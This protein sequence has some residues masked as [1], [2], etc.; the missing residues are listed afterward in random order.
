MRM[1]EIGLPLKETASYASLG[2]ASSLFSQIVSIYLIY[3]YTDVM[4]IPPGYVAVLFLVSHIW[5][6]VNDQIFGYL[7]CRTK[8]RFG[9]YRPYLLW[10]AFPMAALTILLFL[11]PAFTLGW[12][13][14][15]AYVLYFLWD[16][17]MTLLNLSTN[18]LLPMI[19]AGLSERTRLNSSRIIFSVAATLLISFTPNFVNLLGGGNLGLTVMGNP[20][21]GY[22]LTAAVYAAMAV[23]LLLFAFR[24][25]REKYA[26]SA[27]EKIPFKTA[28]RCVGGDRQLLLLFVLFFFI[29]MANTF[30][31]SSTMYYLAHV[32]QNAQLQSFFFF[33]GLG[34]SFVMQLCVRRVVKKIRIIPAVLLG[35]LGSAAGFL[36][37]LVSNGV[38]PLLLAGNIVYGLFSAIPANL[39]FVMLAE[40]VDK[41]TRKY[42]QN[43]ASWIYATFNFGTKVGVSLA[44]TLISTILASAGY[45]AD[46]PITAP[47]QQAMTF[48][49]MVAPS[50]I[51]VF[52]LLLM[53][54]Y[55]WR[56]RDAG[57]LASA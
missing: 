52:A 29:W 12:K 49:F 27:K 23:P 26:L 21:Q 18:S 4:K 32:L 44:G 25:I 50:I 19:S 39:C 17:A 48:N 30:K 45:V 36:L 53:L 31:S 5:D 56:E 57:S 20:T 35:L 34:A 14:V 16:S 6:A 7:M 15:Y 3:F 24:N 54:L 28:L 46:N 1:K 51:Y 10:T 22:P 2:F 38:V 42:K 37:M 11:T 8:S 43:V 40:Y 9:I 33:T 13:I 47:I 41:Y 55:A